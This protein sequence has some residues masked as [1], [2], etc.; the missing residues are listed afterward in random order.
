MYI[1]KICLKSVPA[2]P[3]NFILGGR[4]YDN[5]PPPTSGAQ[6]GCHGK[7]GF[8]ATGRR[9]LHFMIEYIKNAKAYKL[10]IGTYL[11]DVVLVT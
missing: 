1:A 4:H 9:N 8:L 2:G 10:Q 11:Q 5:P 6:D 7:T 3:I